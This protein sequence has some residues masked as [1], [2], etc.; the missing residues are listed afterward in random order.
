[1][2]FF[3]KFVVICLI[4]IC[5]ITTANGYEIDKWGTT[6]I[7]ETLII[8]LDKSDYYDMVIKTY[9]VHLDE[10]KKNK[11]VGATAG[12]ILESANNW[13]N[14]YIVNKTQEGNMSPLISQMYML[15]HYHILYINNYIIENSLSNL[16]KDDK[17]IFMDARAKIN[18]YMRNY[19]R[20]LNEFHSQFGITSKNFRNS[21]M[22]G[23]SLFQKE[24]LVKNPYALT[25]R[26]NG[27]L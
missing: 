13:N 3:M 12:V 24:F 4:H 14:R 1:M 11:L 22:L 10:Q 23:N 25:L 17:R 9:K 7:Q 27:L 8:G 15:V 20:V 6:P 19:E 2:N 26:I 16:H 21:L 18:R 5:T